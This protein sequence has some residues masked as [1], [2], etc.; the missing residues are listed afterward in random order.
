MKTKFIHAF[1]G[2]GKGK[3]SAAIGQALRGVAEGETVTIIQFLKGKN[4]DEFRLIEKLEPD[5]KMFR[6]DKSESYYRDLT[7]EEKEDEK[8][9]ILNGFNY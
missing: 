1:Y 5:V 9:N 6:F 7:I 4:A 8:I 3:T 2:S